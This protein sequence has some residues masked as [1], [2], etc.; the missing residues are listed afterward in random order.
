[1]CHKNKNL[2]G[3]ACIEIKSNSS[4]QQNVCLFVCVF[5]CLTAVVPI[6]FE[7][8]MRGS[9]CLFSFHFRVKYNTDT[10]ASDKTCKLT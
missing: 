9:T 8:D 7:S 1:M 3:V 2:K 6:N 10:Y 5:W 4:V